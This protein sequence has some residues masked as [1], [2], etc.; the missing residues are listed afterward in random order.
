M[1]FLTK[2]G[3]CLPLVVKTALRGYHVYQA[4]WEP[5]VD[6]TFIAL[7]ESSNAHGILYREENDLHLLSKA[8]CSITT[9]WLALFF[10]A[11]LLC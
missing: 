6:E 8:V 5:Q 1:L 4:V 2:N 9:S 3:Y 10:C 11:A 7:Q